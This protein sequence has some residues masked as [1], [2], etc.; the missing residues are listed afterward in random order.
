MNIYKVSFISSIE[1]VVK[2][3]AGFVILKLLAFY[4]GPEGVAKFGQFQNFLTIII[5]FI[6]GSFVTGLVRFISENSNAKKQV[7]LNKL[8][9]TDYIRGAFSFGFLAWRH[10]VYHVIFLIPTNLQQFFIYWHHPYFS[11][12]FIRYLLP[13]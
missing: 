10:I 9:N 3:V 2:L 7:S 11:S 6:A 4:A 12:L 13:I 1:T 8:S 5:V